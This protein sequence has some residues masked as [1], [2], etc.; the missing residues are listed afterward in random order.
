[1]IDDIS[2]ENGSTVETVCLL[3][4]MSNIRERTSTLDVDT[5]NVTDEFVEEDL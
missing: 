3:Q 1:V 2:W 5:V 4:K